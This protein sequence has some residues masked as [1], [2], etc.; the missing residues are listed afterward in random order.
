MDN[1]QNPAAT[2]QSALM[3]S[4]RDSASIAIAH[5]PNAA[6]ANQSSFFQRLIPVYS[7]IEVVARRYKV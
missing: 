4:P 2:I 3:C 6:T 1:A 5:V 7:L